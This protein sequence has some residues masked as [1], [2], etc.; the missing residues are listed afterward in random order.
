MDEQ[1]DLHTVQQ[2]DEGNPPDAGPPEPPR[3]EE[4]PVNEN[5]QTTQD[6]SMEV[7]DAT[8]EDALES[9]SEAAEPPKDVE[10]STD[11][12]PVKSPEAE[13]VTTQE[14]EEEKDN[15]G[16]NQPH[17]MEIHDVPEHDQDSHTDD[18]NASVAPS[19]K[20]IDVTLM[21][22]SAIDPFDQVKHTSANDESTVTDKNTSEVNE[23]AAADSETEHEQTNDE[24]HE[25]DDGDDAEERGG[26]AEPD[27]NK[28]EEENQKETE[29]VADGKSHKILWV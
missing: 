2:I 4:N 27:T 26:D 8:F 22:S 10:M 17:A 18:P 12:Q 1:S 13:K 15:N 21:N 6:N 23:S 14:E 11:E 19:E 25:N 28:D 7:D 20:S 16:D 24:T 5:L 3:T 9:I 29:E